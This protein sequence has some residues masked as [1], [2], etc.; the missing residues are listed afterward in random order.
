MLTW[1]T[2]VEA[3]ALRARGW[4]IS[5]IAAHLEHDRKTIRA[6]LNGQRRPGERKPARPDG[7]A[8]FVGYC[9]QRL[10]DDPHLWLTTLFDEVTGL[11]YAGS[12]PAFTAA[13]RRHQLRPRC[14]A[15]TAAK[16]RDRAV[17]DHPAGEETQWDWLELPDPPAHWGF[18]G[19][20]HLLLGTL[21]HSSR[22]RGWLAECEDQPHLIE[23]LHRVATGLGGLTRRW[24]FDRMATV[25]HPGSGRITASFGPVAVHYQVGISICPSRHAWRKGAVEKS[26]HTIAQR[27]WRTLGEDVT[28]AAAQASLDRLCV[29]LDARRRVRDGQRTTVGELADAEPL[30]AMPAPFPAMIEVQRTVSNQARV[31]FR[32]NQYSI[33]PGHAGEVVTVRHELGAAGLDILTG[34]GTLLAHH[35]RQPD[36]AGAVVRTDEHVAALT[37]VVLADFSDREPCRRKTRRPPSD[38]ALAEADRIRRHRVGD[39][40]DGDH[41][42]VDFASYA[43]QARPIGGPASEQ[44]GQS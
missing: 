14:P 8:G 33:P 22:W 25:C 18:A 24:R 35:V 3:Q 2:C 20:A 37:K 19:K 5:A 43:E 26:A 11:G 30:R 6:Y 34:R 40:A 13:V 29:R 36:G 23:G 7:L 1:E 42:V 39:A 4:S 38:A 41:V 17:I 15:C 21:A 27:W 31:P 10:A 9:A 16:T 44:A 12:Y 28:V 32:G